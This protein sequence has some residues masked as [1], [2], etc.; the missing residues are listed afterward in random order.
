MPRPLFPVC[1]HHHWGRTPCGTPSLENVFALDFCEDNLGVK[2]Q[3]RVDFCEAGMTTTAQTPRPVIVPCPFCSAANRVDLSRLASGPKCAKCGKPLRLDRPQKVTDKDF[4]R[5]ITGST[6]PVL[7]DFY[8][9]WCGP[10]KA[11]APTLDEFA[12]RKAG[13]AL[14]LKL[15]T[16]ANPGI[17]ARYGI[18]GIP[19]LISFL[20]G[21]EKARHVGMADM[22]VLEELTRE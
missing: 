3:H 20:R 1:E 22:K 9:D 14:V 15:D 4:D 16:E 19:T 6:V 17:A 2:M 10:C 8:A 12:V 7:V 11:M 13:E 21:K 18:R 5:T